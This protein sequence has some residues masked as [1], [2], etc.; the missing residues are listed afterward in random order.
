MP[1]NDG[2]PFLKEATAAI[3]V[4][5]LAALGS[6]DGHGWLQ[7]DS[8][9]TIIYSSQASRELVRV[10]GIQHWHIIRHQTSHQPLVLYL[11]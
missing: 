3:E 11:R 5:L 6:H 8:S 9:L 7:A 2:D 4:C 1:F 10:L